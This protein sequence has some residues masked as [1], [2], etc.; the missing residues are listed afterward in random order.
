LEGGGWDA[1][2]QLDNT[3]FEPG[4]TRRIGFVFLSTEGA[5]A[6]KRAGLFYL[7]EGRVVGEAR[8]VE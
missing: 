7:W 2:L 1:R 8:V 3:P 5:E 6:M 4:T